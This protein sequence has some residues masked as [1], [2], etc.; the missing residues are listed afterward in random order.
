M[1]KT[2]LTVSKSVMAL[3]MILSLGAGSIFAQEVSSMEGEELEKIEL[4]KKKKEKYLVIDVRPEEEY[5]AGHLTHAINIPLEELESD[6]SRLEEYK[7]MPIV[8]YCNTGK[9]SG[10]AA[11][12]LLSNGF[13]DVTNAAG[14][15]D[16]EYTLVSF[17][18]ILFDEVVT[19][20]EEGKATFVDVRDAKDF[21]K[22]SL[23]GAINVPV[24]TPEVALEQLPEDKETEIITFCYSGNKSAQVAEFLANEGYT[25]VK[26]SL[27]GTKEK[28]DFPIEVAE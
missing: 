11:D 8:V 13:T 19:A 6:L 20:V 27:Y 17:E 9:K 12:L 23:P 21:E 5:D 15:K 24:E 26:N 4:D 14:V 18:S 10:E 7:E 28:D 1:R 25:N 16:F 2:L 22:G 3:A